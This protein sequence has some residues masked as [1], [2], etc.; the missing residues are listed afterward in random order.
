MLGGGGIIKKKKKRPA[1][2]KATVRDQW[3]RSG[4]KLKATFRELRD[5][6]RA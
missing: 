4:D 5:R 3:I 2:F 1:T 6:L